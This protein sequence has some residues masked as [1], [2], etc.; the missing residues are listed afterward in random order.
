MISRNNAAFSGI[1]NPVLY[2]LIQFFMPEYD[3]LRAICRNESE[4]SK[5]VIDD[6]LLYYAAARDKVDQEFERKTAG[7]RMG[8]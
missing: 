1:S 4:I 6:F 8:R 7:R 5:T 3:Q 2:A